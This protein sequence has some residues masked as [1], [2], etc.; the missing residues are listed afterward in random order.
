MFRGSS[1]NNP[2]QPSSSKRLDPSQ[3]FFWDSNT[4]LVPMASLENSDPTEHGDLERVVMLVEQWEEEEDA[5]RSVTS[6]KPVQ[7][8]SNV[9][10]QVR[11]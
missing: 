5:S 10:T 3:S 9:H 1:Q 11:A 6:S 8:D 4:L 2:E 7:P